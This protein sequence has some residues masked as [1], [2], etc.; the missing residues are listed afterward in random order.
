LKFLFRRNFRNH[1]LKKLLYYK[2]I[3]QPSSFFSRKI[4]EIYS[5]DRSLNYSMDLDLWLK[6][7]KYH[8][9]KYIPQILS[10]NRIHVDRKMIAGKDI[11]I[12][13]ANKLRKSHGYKNYAKVFYSPY[14]RLTDVR[15]YLFKLNFI[16][17]NLMRKLKHKF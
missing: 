1:S 4:F 9:V 5:L 12:E 15:S 13:E 2:S 10:C 17:K 7:F 3:S 6:I 8:R 16:W 11:A 14:Y